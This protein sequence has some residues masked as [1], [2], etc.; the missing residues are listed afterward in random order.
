MDDWPEMI[1]DKYTVKACFTGTVWALLVACRLRNSHI[2]ESFWS[3]ELVHGNYFEVNSWDLIDL[4]RQR[5]GL[6]T[7]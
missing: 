1:E 3:D 7:M 2:C 4:G 5:I 6:I